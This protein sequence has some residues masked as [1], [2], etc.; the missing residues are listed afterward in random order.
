MSGPDAMTVAYMAGYEKG[1]AD[2]R[3]RAAKVAKNF[4]AAGKVTELGFLIGPNTCNA[5]ATAILKD[6]S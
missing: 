3:E 1:K 2:E 6:P 4:P 5:I